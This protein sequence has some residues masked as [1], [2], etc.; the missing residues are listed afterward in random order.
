MRRTFNIDYIYWN[1][2][3]KYQ[4]FLLFD[5]FSRKRCT[6]HSKKQHLDRQQ[7]RHTTPPL[8]STW[9]TD[10]GTDDSS[11]CCCNKFPSKKKPRRGHT[12]DENRKL[13]NLGLW[14]YFAINTKIVL[15]WKFYTLFREAASAELL[16]LQLQYLVA[17][18]HADIALLA[19]DCQHM[20]RDSIAGRVAAPAA[21]RAPET[22]IFEI[23][24]SPNTTCDY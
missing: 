21:A 9:A 8:H 15:Q 17:T 22:T 4:R 1:N 24:L 16:L 7:H 13:C 19:Y 11:C 18:L 6:F 12:N 23:P 10:A 14:R 3:S 20:N 2:L 5:I